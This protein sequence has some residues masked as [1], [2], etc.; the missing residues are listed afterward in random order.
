M[1]KIFAP[2]L[3]GL[4]AMFAQSPRAEPAADGKIALAFVI[5][6]S[7]KLPPP[8]EVINYAKGTWPA[9]DF[10]SAG[11]SR[12]GVIMFTGKGKELGVIT[13]IEAPY[14]ADELQYPCETAYGWPD[15]CAALDEGKAH[16]IVTAFGGNNRMA[17]HIRATMLVQAAASLTNAIG[18]YWGTGES[19]W[20]RDQFDLG[21]RTMSEE[22]PPIPL[23]IGFKVQAESDGI[24]SL[25]TRGMDAFEL[26]NVEIQHSTRQP[27]NSL[28]L[29]SDIAYYLIKSGPVINDGDTI[30]HS[31]EEKLKITFS[32]SIVDKDIT[33]YRLHF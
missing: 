7:D 14:P 33:V 23:W 9:L 1:R 26:M 11:K 16:L 25:V 21:T 22:D 32:P 10:Y 15:A 27:N 17:D 4:T 24:S 29:A 19:V 30:G 3:A 20:S 12:E 6:S 31:A 2:L 5:V 13:L 28:A 8:A 18:V